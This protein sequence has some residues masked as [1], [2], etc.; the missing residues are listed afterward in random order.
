MDR[1]GSP[2]Y[3]PAEISA[4]STGAQ[5]A[6]DRLLVSA[7]GLSVQGSPKRPRG[8]ADA[9]PVLQPLALSGEATESDGCV[10]VSRLEPGAPCAVLTVAPGE[11]VALYRD[12]SPVDLIIGR[13]GEGPG[14]ED[15]GGLVEFP[16][17]ALA[18]DW[19]GGL[20]HTREMTACPIPGA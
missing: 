14:S 13:F 19:K 12:K 2:A 20:T 3:D 8:D 15:Q 11:G 17:D 9:T 4:A 6:A 10:L 5:A 16:A 18:E 1:L 7:L